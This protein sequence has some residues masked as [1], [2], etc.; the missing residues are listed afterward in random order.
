MA[1][2]LSALTA[3]TQEELRPVILDGVLNFKTRPYLNVLNDVKGKKAIPTLTADYDLFQAGSCN[4][5]ASGDVTWG[6]REFDPKSIDVVLKFCPNDL[7][8]YFTR[9]YLPAGSNY[10]EIAGSES[11]AIANLITTR[12]NK[13]MEYVTWRGAAGGSSPISSLNIVDGIF[14][15]ISDEISGGAIPAAQR[16]SGAIAQASIVDTVENMVDALPVDIQ[17]SIYDP[18]Q[19]NFLYLSFEAYRNYIKKYRST[20]S[21]LNYNNEF[22]KMTVDGTN[23]ELVPIHVWDAAG[24]KDNMVLAHASQLWMGTDLES[25]I[26]D[27]RVEKA[28]A[29]SKDIY[30]QTSFKL[31]YQ[32]AKP[33]ELVVNGF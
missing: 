31:S 10:D 7:E 9:G 16:L 33:H 22:N 18:S 28:A 1:F 3:M 29:P 6:Q 25:E 27:L 24:L 26:T 2:D 8:P 32:V 4:P 5:T 30:L 20:F 11:N 15:I 19:R 23:I 17:A 14:E 13:T 21:A 12:I